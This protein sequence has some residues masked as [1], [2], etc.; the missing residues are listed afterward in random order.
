MNLKQI[1]EALAGLTSEQIKELNLLTEEHNWRT[2]PIRIT[3]ESGGGCSTSGCPRGYY[4]DSQS[5]QCILNA[6]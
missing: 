1:A 6:G 3:P 2:L 4:C 5:G